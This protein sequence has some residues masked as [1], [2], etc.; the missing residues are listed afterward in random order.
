[1]E[2]VPNQRIWSSHTFT[3]L[4]VVLVCYKQFHRKFFGEFIKIL[5]KM[6]VLFKIFTNF[7]CNLPKIFSNFLQIFFENTLKYFGRTENGYIIYC[8]TGRE[9]YLILVKQ[10]I[11]KYLRAWNDNGIKMGKVGTKWGEL[12]FWEVVVLVVEVLKKFFL[13]VLW[14][15]LYDYGFFFFFVTLLRIFSS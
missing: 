6:A 15:K 11:G 9:K 1:M 14:K 8:K 2:G 3:Y 4:S 12:N 5:L 13:K 10:S 7:P